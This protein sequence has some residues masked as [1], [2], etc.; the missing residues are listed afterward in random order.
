MTGLVTFLFLYPACR[1]VLNKKGD[2]G[3]TE[4]RK[5]K[6][7]SRPGWATPWVH[8]AFNKCSTFLAST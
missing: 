6:P 5:G 4:M 7:D 1:L 2:E 3:G 8:V